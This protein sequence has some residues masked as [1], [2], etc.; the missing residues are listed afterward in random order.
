MQKDKK[1]IQRVKAG[2]KDALRILYVEHKDLLLTL[3][4]A[5]LHDST[6]AEDVLHEVFV[7]FTRHIGSFRL[8]GSLRAYLATCVTNEARTLLRRHKIHAATSDFATEPPAKESPCPVEAQETAE[9]I[10]VCLAKLP[11]E[12]R[13]VVVLRVKAGLKF[14]DIA[15]IQQATLP[16]VQRRYRYGIDKLRVLLNGELDQ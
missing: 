12:Q 2:D 16:T 3:A 10:R 7:K 8:T 1:L 6:L 11:D 9:Q 15:R 13:E 5:L 14:K 4:N